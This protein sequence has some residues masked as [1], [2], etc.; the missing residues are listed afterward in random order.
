MEEKFINKYQEEPILIGRNDITDMGES[1]MGKILKFYGKYAL[2][3]IDGK[4][5]EQPQEQPQEQSQGQPSNAWQESEKKDMVIRNNLTDAVWR[6]FKNINGI[7]GLPIENR[8]TNRNEY[9]SE[10]RKK[11]KEDNI[12]RIPGLYDRNGEKHTNILINKWSYENN[13]TS[14]SEHTIELD[15]RINDIIEESIQILN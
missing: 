10:F 9:G 2:Y 14:D 5:Y 13:I 11:I 7:P 3:N 12:C 8:N 1:K 15:K 6:I 4:N